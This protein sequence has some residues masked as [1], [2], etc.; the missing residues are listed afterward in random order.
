MFTVPLLNPYVYVGSC[1]SSKAFIALVDVLP[2]NTLV[3][4]SDIHA[5]IGTPVPHEFNPLY[6]IIHFASSKCLPAGM[7]ALLCIGRWQ[8]ITIFIAYGNSGFACFSSTSP[9]R[10]VERG[11]K[12]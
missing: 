10:A 6:Y 4:S 11:G 1:L 7:I 3:I 8:D 9:V 2:M 5:S 12:G